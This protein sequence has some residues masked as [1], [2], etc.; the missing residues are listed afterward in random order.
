[1]RN[2]MRTVFYQWRRSFSAACLRDVQPPSPIELALLLACLAS[3]LQAASVV[4]G[5]GFAAL[6]TPST[7]EEIDTHTT[8]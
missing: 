5:R 1:M 6:Q 3:V 7:R 2:S 8:N 4:R